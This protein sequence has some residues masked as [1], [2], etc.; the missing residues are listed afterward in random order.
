MTSDPWQPNVSLEILEQRSALFTTIRRFFET[1]KFLEVETPLL[2]RDTVIDQHLDPIAVTLAKDPRH[3]QQGANYWLQTSP[4]FCMKRLVAAGANAIFQF[5]KAFRAGEAGRLHNPEFTMVE[6]YRTGD[7]MHAGM[8]LLSELI[9]LTLKRGAA[10]K[11]TYQNAFLKYANIDPHE[12]TGQELMQRL[13]EMKIDIPASITAEDHDGLLDLLLV[14]KIQP[15]LGFNC[16]LILYNYPASQ[17]ALAQVTGTNPAVAQ[18][19]ELYVEGIELANGYHELLDP[20]VLRERN[21]KTN[22]LRTGDG[23]QPL[24][25][26]SHLLAAMQ[27]GLPA[28]AGVA[29]GFDRL[30]MLV[31]EKQSIEEVLAFPIDR[32]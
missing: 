25:E 22:Q 23:K 30:A 4:E 5:C 9:V 20:E 6:W 3:P 11:M 21:K 12:I 31:F 29:L 28:C 18:R 32:A 27:Q 15:R 26:E 2:S 1:R 13:S 7:D 8:E 16:P 17:A 14:E 19:F 24:P 10:Q